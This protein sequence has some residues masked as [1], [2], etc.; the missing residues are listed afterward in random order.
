MQ[1]HNRIEI[2]NHHGVDFEKKFRPFSG[3]FT[4]YEIFEI[5]FQLREVV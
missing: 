5:F 4:E 2:G 1:E 3:F